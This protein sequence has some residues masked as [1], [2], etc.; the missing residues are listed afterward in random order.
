MGGARAAHNAAC[1]AR[2]RHRAG[3]ALPCHRCGAASDGRAGLGRPELTRPV[4]VAIEMARVDQRELEPFLAGWTE[5]VSRGRPRTAVSA[6]PLT[7]SCVPRLYTAG[8]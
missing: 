3:N 4:Q 8:A 7:D 6:G 1:P 5:Q 2:R